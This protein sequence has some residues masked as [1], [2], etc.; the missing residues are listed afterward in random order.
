MNKQAVLSL[1]GGMDSSTLLLHLLAESYEVTALSF[2]YGQKHRVELERAQALVN[3][4]NSH[5]R[6][7]DEYYYPKVKYQVIKLDG[8]SQLIS[9][10]LVTGGAEVPE[11]HYAEENMKVTVVPNRN[12]IFSSI[13]QSVALSI[14]N[15]KNTE[16]EIA[17]GIHAGDHAIYPD[18]RKEFRDID[19]D[20]FCAG[21][22]DANR[23][24]YYTPYIN[25]DKAGI[26]KDG[27]R[28]CEFLHL[29]FDKVYS[30]TNTSYK[31]IQHTVYWEDK[32]GETLS[33]TEWFSDYKSASSVERVEAFMKLGRKDPVNYADEFG[34]VGW[35]YVVEYVK[36]ILDEHETSR[37]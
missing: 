17:M 25:D 13:I 2:D 11:G 15:E 6:Y 31:P 27:L 32:S 1:S 10:A 20:A 5:S 37:S 4:I 22:W 14:A 34:P 33:S 16:V 29:N 30:R 19:Y 8:L 7:E 21:N 35:D 18:C 36:Q 26:L 24:K 12:K 23:V 3:Y 9:S 28:C